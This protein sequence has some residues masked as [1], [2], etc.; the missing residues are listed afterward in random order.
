[1]GS[2]TND[3]RIDSSTLQV[4][5]SITPRLGDDDKDAA[6]VH[7][8][9][10]LEQDSDCRTLPLQTTQGSPWWSESMA[11]RKQR[12]MRY[13]MQLAEPI[14]THAARVLL[15]VIC[16]CATASLGLPCVHL[17]EHMKEQ[18]DELCE[19][20]SDCHCTAW[21]IGPE[22]AIAAYRGM[23]DRGE[24]WSSGRSIF[25][26]KGLPLWSPVVTTATANQRTL[27][28]SPTT[29]T[30]DE[31]SS[32]HGYTYQSHA[33][34]DYTFPGYPIQCYPA[35]DYPVDYRVQ[36]YTYHP[37]APS[38]PASRTEAGMLAQGSFGILTSSPYRKR[39]LVAKIAKA[40]EVTK[41][42]A[43]EKP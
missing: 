2:P 43:D 1:M 8:V 27:H 29:S 6:E 21:I 25:D 17:E 11:Q 39:K 7:A 12:E 31:S 35:Q 37:T 34:Q 5:L 32:P 41:I 23:L 42:T 24:I 40:P 14:G 38:L 10:E 33:Y 20:V 16:K 19:Y 13:T 3:K 18:D 36:N 15:S 28:A 26:S 4:E 9:K 30:S 22:K